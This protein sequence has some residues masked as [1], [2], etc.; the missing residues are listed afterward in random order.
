M[1]KVKQVVY[2]FYLGNFISGNHQNYEVDSI[3][4]EIEHLDDSQQFENRFYLND[5]TSQL[6]YSNV[7]RTLEFSAD[8]TASDCNQSK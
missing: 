7:D 6:N 3:G 4:N 1:Y 5:P 2:L 8:S